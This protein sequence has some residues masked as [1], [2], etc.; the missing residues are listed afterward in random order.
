MQQAL[1][2]LVEG[3]KI[4]LTVPYGSQSSSIGGSYG[5]SAKNDTITVDTNNILFIFMGAFTGLDDIILE[6]LSK[7]DKV[8]VYE[9]FCPFRSLMNVFSLKLLLEI[10]LVARPPI[11][12][13]RLIP[14]SKVV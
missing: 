5:A 2:K 12:V 7:V 11:Q 13:Q 3:T 1:L 6:K 14:L 9:F 4:T 10:Y 8:I